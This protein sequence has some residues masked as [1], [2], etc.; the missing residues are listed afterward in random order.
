[1]KGAASGQWSDAVLNIKLATMVRHLTAPVPAILIRAFRIYFC[2]HIF[3]HTF[4]IHWIYPG[5]MAWAVRSAILLA[6]L[7]SAHK[8]Y[9]PAGLL[10]ILVYKMYFVIDQLPTTANHAFME[11]LVVLFLLLF[12]D[13]PVSGRAGDQAGCLVDGTSVHL[14][15]FAL[16]SIY[17]YSGVQKIVHGFWWQGE[18]LAH[19]LISREDMGM[20]Y[21]G[22]QV[23]QKVEAMLGGLEMTF[24]LTKAMRL[25]TVP[26]EV[27]GWAIVFF[28][29][30]SWLV[31]A[32]ELVP[33]LLILIPRTRSLGLLLIILT[34]LGIAVYSWEVE[35]M[36]ASVGVLLLYFPKHAV[37]NFSIALAV[38]FAWSLFVVIKDI[39]IVVL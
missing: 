30:M 11:T 23:V 38:H 14:T 32:T 19:C 34:M 10:I 15:Q 12:P 3:I 29:I 18:Y 20:W 22:Q 35:F 31:I 37:R 1:M 13:Q 4:K 25:E 26:L 7:L 33:P 8:R 28:I 5:P 21:M 27:P 16:L 24:P 39:R 6:A 36:F 9:Y 17:F 2:F